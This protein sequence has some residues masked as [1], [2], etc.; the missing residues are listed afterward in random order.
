MAVAGNVV[1]LAPLTHF[2]TRHRVAAIGRAGFALRRVMLVPTPEGWP[3]SGFQLA[4][5][6]LQK[7]WQGPAGVVQLN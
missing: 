3:A 4:A 5:V 6:W 1:F 7:G 2:T